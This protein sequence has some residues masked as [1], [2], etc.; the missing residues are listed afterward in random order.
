MI[1]SYG[2]HGLNN[3][4]LFVTELASVFGSVMLECDALTCAAV[5]GYS[6]AILHPAIVIHRGSL[7]QR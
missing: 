2:D 1:E 7:L 4:L 5:S 6:I 3:L